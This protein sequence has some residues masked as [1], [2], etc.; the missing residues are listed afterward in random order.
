M[1]GIIFFICFIIVILHV[2]SQISKKNK[3]SSVRRNDNNTSRP[4]S[5]SA[6][7]KEYS[8]DP[9]TSNWTPQTEKSPFFMVRKSKLNGVWM[10]SAGEMGL[11][12]CR[13]D[14]NN[15]LPS[16]RGKLENF[17]ISVTINRKKESG[18]ETIYR[19]VYPEEVPFDFLLGK[20]DSL[21][22]K[23][24][25]KEKKNILFSDPEIRAKLQKK[26]SDTSGNQIFYAENEDILVKYLAAEERTDHLVW[27]MDV[28]EN[29]MTGK[30]GIIRLPGRNFA[31]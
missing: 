19:I 5:S 31:G 8:F 9:A 4:P 2:L 24:L 16:I 14:D 10:E 7:K 22:C 11:V 30:A 20:A 13:P 1:T 21:R 26:T 27:C 17:D 23:A 29:K 15:I 6:E 18:M 12:F 28:L 3:P 25:L